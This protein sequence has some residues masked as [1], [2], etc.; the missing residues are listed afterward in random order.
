MKLPAKLSA[1]GMV[2]AL[3]GTV[4]LV[5]AI[6]RRDAEI[7]VIKIESTGLDAV[8]T[9]VLLQRHLQTHRG[10]S[11]MVLNGNDS[12][13][14]DRRASKAEVSAQFPV[15]ERQLAERSVTHAND[16]ARRMKSGW[17]QLAAQV[18]ARSITADESF[19]AHSALVEQNIGVIDLVAQGVRHKYERAQSER[20][21]L[22]ALLLASML[23]VI[24]GSVVVWRA[25]RRTQA[26]SARTSAQ[27]SVQAPLHSGLGGLTSQLSVRP[28]A[29]A[30]QLIGRVARKSSAAAPADEHEKV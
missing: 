1:L 4:P 7:A 23:V 24:G 27:T 9:A 25:W 11:S 2:V 19:E 6:Q 30:A 3:I 17:H 21:M 18:E 10:L 8:R 14:P 13:E 15:L 5:G 22:L 26:K 16:A 20:A 28:Q 12:A 29:A